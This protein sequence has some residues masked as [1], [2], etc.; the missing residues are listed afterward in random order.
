MVKYLNDVL[1]HVEIISVD[2][3]VSDVSACVVQIFSELFLH[4]VSSDGLLDCQFLLNNG[5][6]YFAQQRAQVIFGF[7][8][9]RL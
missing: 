8:E 1:E 4:D 3:P 7:D 5:R 2:D 6:V 9:R